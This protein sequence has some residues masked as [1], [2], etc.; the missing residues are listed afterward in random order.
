MGNVLT[1][2]EFMKLSLAHYDEGGD[3]Y[4]ECWDKAQFYQYQAL[5]GAI[6]K[7]K[8]MAMFKLSKSL[9]VI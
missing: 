2:D 4:Y 3:V 8:A 6:T 1:Y 7:K 9:E 5:F